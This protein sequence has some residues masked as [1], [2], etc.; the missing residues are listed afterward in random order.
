MQG[1]QKKQASG[2]VRPIRRVPKTG[3]IPPPVKPIKAVVQ[4]ENG[5]TEETDMNHLKAMTKRIPIKT[6]ADWDKI[7]KKKPSIVSFVAQDPYASLLKRCVFHRDEM[8]KFSKTSA[9]TNPPNGANPIWPNDLKVESYNL[10]G[11]YPNKSFGSVVKGHYGYGYNHINEKKRSSEEDAELKKIQTFKENASKIDPSALSAKSAAGL[12]VSRMFR[13]DM[14][15]RKAYRFF[16]I[17]QTGRNGYNSSISNYMYLGYWELYGTLTGKSWGRV[18]NDTVKQLKAGETKFSGDFFQVKRTVPDRFSL[19]LPL[20]RSVTV[21]RNSKDDSWGFVLDSYGRVQN[22]TDLSL[23]AKGIISL[24][25]ASYAYNQITAVNGVNIRD[26]DGFT[27]Q[28]SMKKCIDDVMKDKTTCTLTFG[29][30][31]Y[32]IPAKCNW[33][34]SK[35]PL[36]FRIDPKT[37]RIVEVNPFGE[38]DGFKI[39]MR[40]TGLHFYYYKAS[41]TYKQMNEKRFQDIN[42]RL[43][44]L[45]ASN[46]RFVAVAVEASKDECMFV[47]SSSDK[48]FSTIQRG[49]KSGTRITVNHAKRDATRLNALWVLDK[50]LLNHADLSSFSKISCVTDVFTGLAMKRDMHA[51][52]MK[53]SL[54]KVK[55]YQARKYALDEELSKINTE[56][57]DWISTRR[58]KRDEMEYR[59]HKDLEILHGAPLETARLS[60]VTL[61]LRKKISFFHSICT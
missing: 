2:Y 3:K 61:R 57:E 8:K 17:Q 40:V 4:Y 47:H 50:A 5:K 58:M 15:K 9:F 46:C 51:T 35:M 34:A 39:G 56:L 11:A 19:Q 54:N 29:R 23:E 59:M 37:F 42:T 14:N 53:R 60:Y 55:Y 44:Q 16:R 48:F 30:W 20:H 24:Q 27:G 33:S 49:G 25:S 26:M 13:S 10:F 28:S 31:D 41:G 32:F 52:R 7:E 12:I 21:T 43:N 22:V 1:T 45:K 6:K 36:G 18:R 38:F